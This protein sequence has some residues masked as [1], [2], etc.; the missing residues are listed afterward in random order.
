MLVVGWGQ[1]LEAPEHNSHHNLHLHHRKVAADAWFAAK[2]EGYECLGVCHRLCHAVG[3][4]FRVESHGILP[5]LGRVN[6]HGLHWNLYGHAFGNEEAAKLHIFCDHSWECGHY[7]KQS[8]GFIQDHANLQSRLNSPAFRIKV[9]ESVRYVAGA[10]RFRFDTLL[11]LLPIRFTQQNLCCIRKSTMEH[12]Q[13][14]DLSWFIYGYWKCLFV[15][16]SIEYYTG[17]PPNCIHY[18][19]W[20]SI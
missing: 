17:P 14:S 2:S 13:Q 19:V 6:V 8:H 7:R 9:F 4:S 11:Q 15:D 3:K 10:I 1:D 20:S 16:F 5:P 18:W 12:Q